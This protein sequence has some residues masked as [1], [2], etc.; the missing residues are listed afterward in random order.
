MSSFEEYKKLLKRYE[1]AE[2]WFLKQD[3]SYFEDLDNKVEYKAFKD[4]VNK[5]NELFLKLDID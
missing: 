5:L 2:K 4:I 3:S 1:D